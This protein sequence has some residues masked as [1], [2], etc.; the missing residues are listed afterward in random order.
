MSDN[1]PTELLVITPIGVPPYSIRNASQQLQPSR[2]SVN[3]KRTVNGA[4]INLAPP[5]LRKYTSTIS[6][7]DMDSPAL[8]GVMPGDTVTIECISELSYLTGG[9]PQRPVVVSSDGLGSPRIDGDFTFYRPLLVMLVTGY[10]VST[11]EWGAM[12]AWK[13]DLEEV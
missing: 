5:Q 3:M 4:L 6:C 1:G 13:L 11:D 10:E 8:D 7:T 2:A 9:S 12:V